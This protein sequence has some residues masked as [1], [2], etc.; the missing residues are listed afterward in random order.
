MA[1]LDGWWW[2]TRTE[3]PWAEGGGGAAY[4]SRAVIYSAAVVLVSIHLAHHNIHVPCLCP[5]QS[6][7]HRKKHFAFYRRQNFDQTRRPFA[8]PPQARFLQAR[9]NQ[10][11]HR[12]NGFLRC[13]QPP[14]VSSD[15][16]LLSSLGR[17]AGCAYCDTAAVCTYAPDDSAKSL[18]Q[19]H[20][21]LVQ[22]KGCD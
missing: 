19:K 18:G 11:L 10:I 5:P 8:A 21:N 16:S 6:S 12:F 22:C 4:Q 13:P 3:K 17:V 14:G 15:S 9:R 20:S 1:R 7:S 2:L